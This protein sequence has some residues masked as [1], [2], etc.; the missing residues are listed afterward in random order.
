MARQNSIPEPAWLRL[1]GGVS[2]TLNKTAAT[3]AATLLVMMVLLILL[4]IVL[5]YHSRSTFMAD[6]L[7]GH[8][9]AATTFLALGWALE[10]GSMIRISVVT[11]RLRPSPR[12]AA[13][14]FTIV[15]TELL[16]LCLMYY[17]WRTV[18]KLWIRGSVSQ[19]YFPIPLRIP[20]AIFFIGL[21]LLALQLLVR[22]CR[23]GVV[24]VEKDETL[25][26]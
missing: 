19:H 8:G 13:E 10:R 18:S 24:G 7:V 3:V 12:F 20:E 14:A 17:Q 9:V 6:A 4:E 2:S 15:A 1:I 22:L 25:T 11:R 5:R 21:V 16:I 23:L 26:L